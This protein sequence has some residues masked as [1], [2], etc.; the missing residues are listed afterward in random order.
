MKRIAPLALAGLFLAAI[1]GVSARP[2]PTPTPTEEPEGEVAGTVVART[3]GGWLGVEV[4]DRTFR[5]T[6]YNAKKQPVPADATSVVLRWPVRYQPNDE[7]TEL[8]PTDDPA[9]LASAYAVK[10]PLLFKLHIT[11][12]VEGKTDAPESYVIDFRG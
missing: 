3:G 9:V 8:L 6:F 10:G 1:G 2:T 11:L 12:L 4:K 7:R 5:L